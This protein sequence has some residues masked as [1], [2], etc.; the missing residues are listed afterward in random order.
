MQPAYDGSERHKLMDRVLH[1]EP[2]RL[3]KLA[4]T[5]PRDLETIIQKTIARDPAQR[6]SAPERLAEDLQRFIDDKPIKARHATS[7]EKVMRWC[8]RNPALSSLSAGLLLLLV[9]TAVASTIAAAR[10]SAMAEKERQFRTEAEAA[11]VRESQQRR[12]T[13]EALRATEA[14][15]QN[16]AEAR[17]RAEALSKTRPKLAAGPRP[18]SKRPSASRRWPRRI[19]R[20]PAMPWTIISPA[21]ARTGCSACPVCSRCARSYSSRHS[22]TIAVSS[23]RRRTTRLFR[24]TWRWLMRG[25]PASRPTSARRARR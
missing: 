23:V 14:A 7:T 6:Y 13:D 1:E 25:S 11:F 17:R 3:K 22:L 18:I 21:S 8:R 19:S 5:V 20:S 15:Q 10:F 16:E 12:K 9:G 4:P 24:K 2:V